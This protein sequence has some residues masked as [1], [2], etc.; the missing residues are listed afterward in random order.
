M[1]EWHNMLWKVHFV[2]EY[3]EKLWNEKKTIIPY[4]FCMFA[5]FHF[6][7]FQVKVFLAI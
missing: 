2:I 4:N 1:Q 6:T 7:K 3:P 5:F